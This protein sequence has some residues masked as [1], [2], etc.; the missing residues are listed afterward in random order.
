MIASTER[1]SYTQP[2]KELR[3]GLR[4]R[5]VLRAGA[6]A[7]FG[8]FMPR[9]LMA[10]DR[11]KINLVNTSGNTNLVLAALL[12]QEG[13][14]DQLGLDANILHVADGSKLIGSLL[15]GESDMCALSGFGQVLPAIEKGAKLKVLAGGAVLTLQAIMT[16]KAAI[17]SVKDLEGRTIGT[18]SLGALLHQLVV[19]LLRKK[20]VDEKKVT[21]VNVGSST[22]VFRAIAA[23]T[24]DAG[25]C[26]AW[27]AGRAGTRIVEEGRFYEDLPEYT[28]QAS[29][30]SERAIGRKRDAIVR[31]L[32][33]YGK[34]YRFLS[35][36]KSR[37]PFLKA[38]TLATGKN[39]RAEAEAQWQFYQDHKP[40]A[41]D[42]VLSPERVRYMQDL[43]VSLGVQKSVLPFE[44]VCDMSLAHDAVKL[45]G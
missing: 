31:T 10:A 30:T 19:A 37:E 11:V 9:P 6:A 39:D 14:F 34:L 27:L 24:I 36:A 29:Y 22:D 45:L 12:K 1:N 2:C 21:F 38:F 4:R 8:L 32:A 25:P 35:E 5:E 20:G 18:G 17:K 7:T 43:N 23:G 26:E 33:A 41:V 44:R 28:Y 15:S 13:M 16:K 3:S 40:F 42:L